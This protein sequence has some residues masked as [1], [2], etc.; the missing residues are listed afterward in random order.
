MSFEK[1]LEND[2]RGF[3]FTFDGT[4]AI[5]ISIIGLAS[6]VAIGSPT[7]ISKQRRFQELEDHTNE[8]LQIM[9]VSGTLDNVEDLV[10]QGNI[11]KAK[12]LARKSLNEILSEEK[13]FKMRIGSGSN[14][15]LDSI[16]PNPTKESDEEEWNNKF[17]NAGYVASCTRISIIDNKFKPVTLYLWIGEGV[18]ESET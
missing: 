13:Q 10:E 7:S 3:I 18:N 2:N 8:A 11:Q 4:L 9:E 15:L 17:E 12:D 14:Y 5:L 16:Y 1:I 6:V